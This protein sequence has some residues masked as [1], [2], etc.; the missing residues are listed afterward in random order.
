MKHY[1]LFALLFLLSFKPCSAVAQETLL[2]KP[3]PSFTLADITGTNYSLTEL[4]GKVV[5]LNFWFIA[6][7]PCVNEMARLNAIKARYKTQKVIFLALCLDKKEQIRDFLKTH[8]FNYTVFPDAAKIADTYQ[9]N[10][11]PASMVIDAK[12]VI[13]FI[14][15]GGPDIEHTLPIAIT[16]AIK[17]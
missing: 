4:K 15:I 9:V 16:S 17:D 14:Q 5:V 10:A 11:Y 2:D 6:C 7:K 8:Q 12:G 3:A 13:R 1:L